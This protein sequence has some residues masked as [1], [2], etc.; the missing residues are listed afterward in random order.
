MVES[1]QTLI[2]SQLKTELFILTP[3]EKKA[4]LKLIGEYIDEERTP[5][6]DHCFL[7]NGWIIKRAI[8]MSTKHNYMIIQLYNLIEKHLYSKGV[9]NAK[10]YIFTE[11]RLNTNS[12][13]ELKRRDETLPDLAV[14][15]EEIPGD[16]GSIP[17]GLVPILIIEILS[18]ST[19]IIDVTEKKSKYRRLGVENYWILS[20][21]NDPNEGLE[22]SLFFHL[23]NTSYFDQTPKYQETGIISCIDLND[24]KLH[25]SEIWFEDDKYDTNFQWLQAERKAEKERKRADL[26]EEKLRQM[27]IK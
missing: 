3:L 25:A 11:N 27:E 19:A 20:K 8:D 6:P 5:V 7:R 22:Q 10:N 15:S 18:Q 21:S 4:K 23:K 13:S 1:N 16:K 2:K 24:L 14:Y 12:E 9:K 26:L 17:S